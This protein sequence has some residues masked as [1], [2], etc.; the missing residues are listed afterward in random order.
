MVI[1]EW[2]MT[3]FI[4]LADSILLANNENLM[5]YLFDDQHIW[6]KNLLWHNQNGQ[7]MSEKQF[8]LKKKW[9]ELDG[10]KKILRLTTKFEKFVI[11]TLNY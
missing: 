2:E 9:D 11:W 6:W 8:N 7:S 1:I 3:T 10:Y 4:A 5:F